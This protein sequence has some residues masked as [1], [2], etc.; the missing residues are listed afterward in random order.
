MGDGSTGPS[1][2][3]IGITQQDLSL[4]PKTPTPPPAIPL[5]KPPQFI[6]EFSRAG[7]SEE[8]STLAA[9]IKDKRSEHF[10]AK[11]EKAGKETQLEQ[12][13]QELADTEGA[14]QDIPDSWF[15]RVMNYRRL[16]D[17]RTQEID[18]ETV[19]QEIQDQL[20]LMATTERRLTQDGMPITRLDQARDMVNKFYEREKDKWADSEYTKEDVQKL[21]S[22]EHLS[23]LSTEDYIALL[24]RFPSDMVTHVTRQ[25]IR[26]HVKIEEHS[27]GV[28]QY[29]DGFKNI[30]ADGRIRSILGTYTKD[31]VSQEAILNLLENM[32]AS[33]SGDPTKPRWL[34][35]DIID[36]PSMVDP[37]PYPNRSAV[38]VAVGTVADATYGA[39]SG[40][41]VFFAFPTAFITAH[42][43]FGGRN[44]NLSEAAS[45]QRGLESA[46]NDVNVWSE[47]NDGISINAGLV[48][49]PADAQVDQRTGSKYTLGEDNQPIKITTEDGQET[50]Q[51][52][53]DTISSEEYWENYFREH[54]QQ[55]PKRIIYYEGGDPSRELLDWRKYNGLRKR[56]KDNDFGFPER[57]VLNPNDD[58]RSMQGYERFRS[59][60]ER[61]LETFNVRHPQEKAA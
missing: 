43:F 24:R 52:A 7:S 20:S 17:L 10:R 15:G 36:G 39:E 51:L 8:R 29:S 9:Q 31:G 3:E 60:A 57:R 40:N 47:N 61:A 27:S 23:S 56:S 58:P 50:Y 19:N 28:G 37:D 35:Q 14:L 18:L 22:E 42:N 12:G 30:L 46:W 41:E 1:L 6:R 38:H 21:F 2:A 54:P 53:V 33:E 44:Y 49:I 5:Q 26:D 34:I 11:A 59:I 13:L 16:R 32:T 55:K 48:F 4:V 25:G 45:A